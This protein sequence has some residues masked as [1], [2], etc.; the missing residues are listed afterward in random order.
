MA[1]D[2]LPRGS[3]IEWKSASREVTGKRVVSFLG[4][5]RG[6]GGGTWEHVRAVVRRT[7][8]LPGGNPRV[9]G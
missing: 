5:P 4:A 1:A 9:S 7:H 8:P 3:V 2:V 6:L